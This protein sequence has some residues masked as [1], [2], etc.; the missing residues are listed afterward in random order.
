M[1]NKYFEAHQFIDRGENL[2]GQ[3]MV[4]GTFPVHSLTFP[5]TEDKKTTAR[6]KN[7]VPIFYGSHRNK[8]W[9]WYSLYVDQLVEINDSESIWS[10]LRQKQIA[11]SDVILEISGR[12]GKLA[13][14]SGLKGKILNQKLIKRI[15]N[16]VVT[17]ILCTSKSLG[18]DSLNKIL[19]TNGFKISNQLSHE[20]HNEFL[21]AIPNAKLNISNLVTRVYAKEGH[22]LSVLCIPSPGGNSYRTLYTFG[23]DKK[24]HDNR[25]YIEHYIMN[26]FHWFMN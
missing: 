16:P 15:E 19:T 13:S 3:R 17:K 25:D 2:P 11:I 18:L 6:E 26:A 7:D 20:L 5:Q 10:S 14:D 21:S 12:N 9:E 1:P 8:F 22:E 4:I 23:Y 24:V